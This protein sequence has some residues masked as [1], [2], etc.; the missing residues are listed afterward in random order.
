MLCL[1]RTATN[2]FIIDTLCSLRKAY[3]SHIFFQ[4]E[5]FTYLFTLYS[6]YNQC[7]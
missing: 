5:L 3:N 6:V 1:S 4:V 7:A 2:V